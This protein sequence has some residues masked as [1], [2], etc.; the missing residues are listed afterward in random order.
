MQY[1]YSVKRE[2]I[3]AVKKKPYSVVFLQNIDKAHVSFIDFLLEILRDGSIADENGRT[4]DFSNTLIIMTL[5]VLG[6]N[7]RRW[8]C[9]CAYN[10]AENLPQPEDH[11]DCRYLF[12][13]KHVWWGF[14]FIFFI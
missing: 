9:D 7:F 2:L 3:D 6:H 14:Y 11:D 13:L 4:T 5:C 1:I 8:E 10:K 12:L